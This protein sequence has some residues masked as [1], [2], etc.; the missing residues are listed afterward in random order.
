MHYNQYKQT[1]LKVREP[2]RT[3]LVNMAV[4]FSGTRL[5]ELEE[6]KPERRTLKIQDSPGCR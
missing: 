2:S 4:S 5:F 6:E 1:H 3:A